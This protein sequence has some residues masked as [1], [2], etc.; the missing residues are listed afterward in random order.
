M[1]K[2]LF[3]SDSLFLFSAIL[4]AFCGITNTVLYFLGDFNPERIAFAYVISNLAIGICSIILYISYTKHNKNIMKG[5]IGLLLGVILIEDA[6]SLEVCFN[7]STYGVIE[8]ILV[9]LDIALII[10]HIILNSTHYSK[11]STIKINQLIIV[12]QIITSLYLLVSFISEHIT[13]STLS[14]YN[15]VDSIAV[16]FVFVATDIVIVCV[17]SRLDWFKEIREKFSD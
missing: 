16:T 10:N 12:L 3:T 4:S 6:T 2:R 5:V 11:P 17:E 8:L 14:L 7:T 1:F 15:I 13:N 9:I